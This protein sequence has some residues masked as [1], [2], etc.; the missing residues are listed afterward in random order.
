MIKINNT[1][2]LFYCTSQQQT[3]ACVI[4]FFRKEKEIDILNI[5]RVLHSRCYVIAI[6]SD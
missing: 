5:K 6:R 4:F 3:S 1:N 2:W